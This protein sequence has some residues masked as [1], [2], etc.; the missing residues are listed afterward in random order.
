MIIQGIKMSEQV[1]NE[2][3]SPSIRPSTSDLGNS[4]TR[5][6]QNPSPTTTKSEHGIAEAESKITGGAP[7]PTSTSD[8]SQIRRRYHSMNDVNR[9]AMSGVPLSSSLGSFAAANR[10][11]AA[12]PV[13]PNALPDMLAKTQQLAD[14]TAKSIEKVAAQLRTVRGIYH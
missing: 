3:N 4:P 9:A 14:S 2:Q 5:K 12:P 8:P 13:D 1:A 11:A 6:P 7:P 10:D